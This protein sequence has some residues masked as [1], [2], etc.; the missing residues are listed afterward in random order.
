MNRKQLTLLIILAVIVCAAGVI[1]YN[2]SAKSWQ[3]SSAAGAKVLG[4]FPLNDVAHIVIKSGTA[5]LNLAKK[6][7]VWSVRERDDYPADF[8]RTSELIRILWELKAVQE[9]KVGH[10]QLGRLNL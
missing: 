2:R 3:T 6:N 9:I 1:V 8:S 4:D 5:E 7:D 10:S